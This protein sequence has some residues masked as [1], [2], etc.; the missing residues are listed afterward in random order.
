MAWNDVLAKKDA[1]VLAIGSLRSLNLALI[2]RWWWRLK[3]E[4]DSLWSKVIRFLHGC[5]K[6]LVIDPLDTKKRGVWR[7]ISELNKQLHSYNMDLNLHFV[8]N[9]NI[10]QPK[11]ATRRRT[12]TVPTLP[13]PGVY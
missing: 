9:N 6:N 8:S 1:G 12:T 2:S 5:R 3:V 10:G 11:P 4:N 7:S 13:A